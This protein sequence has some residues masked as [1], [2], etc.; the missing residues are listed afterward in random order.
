[1]SINRIGPFSFVSLTQPPRLVAQQLA[2][3][4]R[5]GVDGVMLQRLG[6]RC[7]PFQVESMA[8]APTHYDAMSLYDQYRF[9]VGAAAVNVVWANI[10]MA[11]AYHQYFVLA[12]DP[13]EI[14]A[15]LHGHGGLNGISYGRC[16]CLWTLQPVVATSEE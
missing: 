4:S 10:P 15:I 7:D 13:I 6:I 5:P 12:V 9:L 2:V 3:R 16:K 8:D 11:A 14:R 1:M